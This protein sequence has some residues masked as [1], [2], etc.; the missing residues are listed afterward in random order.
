[1]RAMRMTVKSAARQIVAAPPLLLLERNGVLQATLGPE[2]VQTTFQLERARLADI[3]FEDFAVIA[4]RL[5]RGLHPFVVEAEPRTEIAGNA[6]QALDGRR[7]RFR[8]L[9]DI[10]LGHAEFLGFEQ[11]VVQPR[12]DVAPDLVAVTRERSERLLADGDRPDWAPRSRPSPQARRRPGS[13][14]RSDRRRKSAAWC[15][16]DRTPAASSRC[17]W[18]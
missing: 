11:A 3:A 13:W 17:R 16:A 5:E 7:G 12:D 8:H 1:M 4:G 15:R 9:V 10:G 18:R 6:E 14:H 2:R